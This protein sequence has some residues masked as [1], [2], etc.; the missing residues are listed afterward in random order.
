M[1]QCSKI[2]FFKRVGTAFKVSYALPS[3]IQQKEKEADCYHCWFSTVSARIYKYRLLVL[4]LWLADLSYIINCVWIIFMLLLLIL[5]I[6]TVH[7]RSD[8]LL[9][10]NQYY[11]R[12]KKSTINYISIKVWFFVHIKYVKSI[13]SITDEIFLLKR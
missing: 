7:T 5:V 1:S 3:D 4:D 10:F 2:H 12:R 6:P 9:N 13:L 8:I 11:C